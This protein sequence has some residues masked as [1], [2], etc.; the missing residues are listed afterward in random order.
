MA[1]SGM[2]G[3]HV[4]ESFNLVNLMNFGGGGLAC[5]FGILAAFLE[6]QRTG[7]GQIVDC[8]AMEG[9]SYIGT[10]IHEVMNT[11]RKGDNIKLALNPKKGNNVNHFPRLISLKQAYIMFS[12]I[13]KVTLQCYELTKK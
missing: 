4:P 6:K 12:Y 9:I 3:D 11:F 13:T 2:L 7:K 8:S 10:W 5:A 1:L